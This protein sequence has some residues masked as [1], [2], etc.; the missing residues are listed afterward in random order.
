MVRTGD[1]LI[2]CLSDAVED[3]CMAKPSQRHQDLGEKGK[4]RVDTELKNMNQS[5]GQSSGAPR[6]ALPDTVCKPIHCHEARQRYHPPNL[7]DSPWH[8]K[9]TIFLVGLIVLLIIWAITYALLKHY[10]VI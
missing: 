9:K 5:Q 7:A 2:T 6:M 3:N 1:I 8:I 10:D 4:V